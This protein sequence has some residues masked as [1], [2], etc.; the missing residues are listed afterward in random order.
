MGDDKIGS[1]VKIT[2]NGIYVENDIY[3]YDSP[4]YIERGLLCVITLFLY[5]FSLVLKKKLKEKY[6]LYEYKKK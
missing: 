2:T 5:I 3:C 1:P 4:T 6:K